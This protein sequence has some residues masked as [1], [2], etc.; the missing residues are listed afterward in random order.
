VR[1]QFHRSVKRPVKLPA[2][3]RHTPDQ[4]LSLKLIPHGHLQAVVDGRGT[5]EEFLTVTFRV[6]VGG[7]LTAFA[8]E[9]G[10]KA[11]EGVYVDALKALVSVGERYERLGKFGCNG[12][13]LKSLKDAIN[14]T[15]D[16]QEVTTRRQQAEM[17]KQVMGFVG[18]FAFTMKNLR[19]LVGK[20]Q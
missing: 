15:D 13:E 20:M 12:D 5:E 4:E 17:Y 10:E 11:L 2:I 6:M 8:D 1:T 9:A 3:F 14:L 19:T 18:G 16:L 7:S